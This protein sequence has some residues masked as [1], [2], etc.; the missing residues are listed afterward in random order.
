MT[1]KELI[2]F[3]EEKIK[4][5]SD[6]E[7]FEKAQKDEESRKFWLGRWGGLM[8]VLEAVKGAK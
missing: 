2:N 8:D 5:A 7:K 3:L 1:K 4:V 6:M